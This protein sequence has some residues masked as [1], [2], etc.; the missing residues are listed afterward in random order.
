MPRKQVF[1]KTFGSRAEVFH[2]TAKK[3]TGGLS[4][5]D[6]VKNKHGDIVSK[7]KH[8]TAKKEKRL[9]KHGYFAKKG[10]FGY[11]KKNMKASKSTKNKT[12]K[13]TAKKGKGKGKR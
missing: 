12:V 10:K 5:K 6:L 8:M 7:K 2:G 9:E 4:K 3:T 11:V 1:K 13:R